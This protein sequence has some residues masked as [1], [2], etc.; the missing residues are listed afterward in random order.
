[1]KAHL[2]VPVQHAAWQAFVPVAEAY[3]SEMIIPTAAGLGHHFAGV[4]EPKD[5]VLEVFGTVHSTAVKL[6]GRTD[7]LRWTDV[8]LQ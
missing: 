3:F 4:Y 8:D 1:M 2:V 5:A 7:E 6:E